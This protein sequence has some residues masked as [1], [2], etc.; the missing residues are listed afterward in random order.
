LQGALLERA[1]GVLYLPR[2][3]RASHYFVAWLSRQ[4]DAVFHL[5]ETGAL[6]PLSPP[7]GWKGDGLSERTALPEEGEV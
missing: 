2:T 7:T 4:F 3:E 6:E 5:D 1:I